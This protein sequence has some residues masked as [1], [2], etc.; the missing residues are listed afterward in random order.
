MGTSA[1]STGPNNQSPLIPSW[2]EQSPPV[3][4]EPA[5]DTGSQTGKIK[6]TRK[7]TMKK[8]SRKSANHLV[9]PILQTVLQELE[10]NSGI[11]PRPEVQALI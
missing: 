6:V 1:S 7:S 11:M 10:E 9:L 5:Q 8:F 4:I 2:A 3:T